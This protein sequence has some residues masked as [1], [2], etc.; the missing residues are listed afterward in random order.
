MANQNDH[1]TM[2]QF[3][4]SARSMEDFE[5]LERLL[6]SR[7]AL[8]G[9]EGE[10][11]LRGA[12]DRIE[13]GSGGAA[14]SRAFYAD[15]S[16]AE[17][18]GILKKLDESL[19]KKHGSPGD[20]GYT[21]P[22]ISISGGPV[23]FTTGVNTIMDTALL[24]PIMEL[25]KRNGGEA[26]FEKGAGNSALVR[27][28]V[29]SDLKI[30]GDR[31]KLV[32]APASV[33]SQFREANKSSIRAFQGLMRAVS[34]KDV[35]EA[36]IRQMSDSYKAKLARDARTVE[37]QRDIADN[38]EELE[39]VVGQKLLS[40]RQRKRAKAQALFKGVSYT[41]EQIASGDFYDNDDVMD[42]IGS[43]VVGYP[44]AIQKGIRRARRRRADQDLGPEDYRRALY[45]SMDQANAR[46]KETDG[47]RRDH[48]D[49]PLAKKFLE[50][51]ERRTPGTAAFEQA[52]QDRL[53][54]SSERRKAAVKW[55]R[56]NRSDPAAK[57]ILRSSRKGGVSRLLRG[58]GAMAR[59]TVLMGISAALA[60]AVKFLSALP[61]VASDVRHL[62]AKGNALAMTDVSLRG[63][64]HMEQVTGMEDGS[65]AET[66]G[67]IVHS[68][69]DIRTGNSRM[70]AIVNDI[71]AVSASDPNSQAVAK[72]IQF[73]LYGGNPGDLW[74]EYLNTSFRLAYLDKGHLG[75]DED[76]SNS[77]RNSL[78]VYEAAAP[79]ITG[80]GAAL[81]AALGRMTPE[82]KQM[83]QR[84]AGGESLEIN[85]K[86]VRGFE[87]YD[88]LAALLGVD[89]SKWTP[90]NTA[91][92]VELKAAEQVS[93]SWVELSTTVGEIKSGVLAQILTAT[94]GI[95]VWLRDILKT[96][97]ALPIFG[98][99]FD[100]VLAY[101]DEEDYRKNVS[102]KESLERQKL[103]AEAS[104]RALGEPF[105]MRTDA[106]H[107]AALADWRSGVGVPAHY[108]A[109]GLAGVYERYVRSLYDLDEV[110]A[111]L[112]GVDGM[113][114]AYRTGSV[115][116]PND[117]TKT[118]PRSLGGMSRPFGWRSEQVAVRVADRMAWD[119]QK[120][121]AA[122]AEVLLTKDDADAKYD[123]EKIV[124]LRKEG[125]RII[126][127]IRAMEDPYGLW[128]SFS[129]E[130]G[131]PG[132]DVEAEREKLRENERAIRSELVYRGPMAARRAWD[133]LTAS[134]E[135]LEAARERMPSGEEVVVDTNGNP[136]ALRRLSD[137]EQDYAA[138]L[139]DYKRVVN[140]QAAAAMAEN[141]GKTEAE[142]LSD[143]RNLNIP[144]SASLTRVRVATD[145]ARRD[146][147]S[148]LAV[149]KQLYETI[150]LQLG[151][152][153]AR[154]ALR[155]DITVSGTI[156]AEEK[157]YR[158]E[159]D[160]RRT[161][162]KTTIKDAPTDGVLQDV[163]LKTV[164]D[165]FLYAYNPA[166]NDAA[167]G[168]E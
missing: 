92:P 156:K 59:N 124:A 63:Y 22:G 29:P 88:A 37:T 149:F 95:S 96:I 83:A 67:A 100:A 20:E 82:E 108:R 86:A 98:G 12:R 105:G 40:D 74:Q 30:P 53:D 68:M 118:I 160:D 51:E 113:L 145:E 26:A 114:S 50:D 162:E 93:Q 16:D 27:W 148:E 3:V 15:A 138:A 90:K 23:D 152:E 70:A 143:A 46:M 57:A 157:T 167:T 154:S 44:V 150:T 5:K 64:R 137:F 153:V 135:A 158:I 147:Q 111:K 47:W 94:E 48:P 25:I 8:L 132:P 17:A 129:R 119:E 73:G 79:G 91:T 62:S 123:S 102:A 11:V 120:F 109:A 140:A 142:L 104:A 6:K 103:G 13:N 106:D 49:E 41:P 131:L 32:G 60:A 28:G 54:R 101:M 71:A 122:V 4:I 164:W 80:Q 72:T 55:A 34:G 31:G 2:Q 45:S 116:D 151:E 146:N 127:R 58:V 42:Q 36:E 19:P 141:S 24:K 155:G 115:P 10:R 77:L 97:M 125:D 56:A 21:D 1:K 75:S 139:A 144:D 133:R 87:V 99:R 130:F 168:G 35:S 134:R 69:P 14:M 61:G 9:Q 161:G 52:E 7:L 128:Q 126:A 66:F 84:V 65:L 89:D 159:L 121:V 39:A 43:D 18:A 136:L 107:A 33:R 165:G 78:G 163:D 117:P 166:L 38:P 76:F 85:G 110:N 112:G 81:A